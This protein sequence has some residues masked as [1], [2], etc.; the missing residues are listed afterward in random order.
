[1]VRHALITLFTITLFLGSERAFAQSRLRPIDT[2][3]RSVPSWINK[4]MLIRCEQITAEDALFSMLFRYREDSFTDKVEFVVRGQGRQVTGSGFVSAHS[5]DNLLVIGMGD[6]VVRCELE[7]RGITL[8]ANHRLNPQ[9]YW[10]DRVDTND[11]IIALK[12]ALPS[13]PF[14][15]VGMS[16]DTRHAATIWPPLSL[17]EMRTKYITAWIIPERG[18]GGSQLMLLEDNISEIWMLTNKETGEI[19]RVQCDVIASGLT[20]DLFCEDDSARRPSEIPVETVGR[21]R[22]SDLAAL[23]PLPGDL[24][25]GS[26]LPPMLL[27][28]GPSDDQATIDGRRM[29][30]LYRED[31]LPQAFALAESLVALDGRLAAR[32]TSLILPIAVLDLDRASATSSQT[33]A[34]DALGIPGA[35]TFSESGTIDRFDPEADVVLAVI[36]DAQRIRN[37]LL[38]PAADDTESLLSVIESWR[39]LG[40]Q[41]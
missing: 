1:M 13:T 26:L 12:E 24:R 14:P 36:D 17:Y 28:T 7:D 38:D 29:V 25:E 3:E 5:T 19:V 21:E 41:R 23:R 2:A 20:I 37:V 31:I 9:Y 10:Q 32:K 39:R 16:M 33:E 8:T 27:V 11:M 30:L 4:G 18:D 34:W 35:W 40:V 22:V 15:Q 6:L